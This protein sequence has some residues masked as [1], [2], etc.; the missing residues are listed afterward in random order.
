MPC[1]GR[2][3]R[4]R[5]WIQRR[6]TRSRCQ[7]NTVAGVTIR[8]SRQA[9]DSNPA[10]AANT[11]RSAHDSRG[12]LTWRRSTATHAGGPG[13]PRSSIVCSGPAIRTRP[14]AVGRSDRAV[15]PSRLVIMPDGHWLVMPQVSTV[16]DLFGTHTVRTRS[17]GARPARRSTCCPTAPGYRCRWPYRPP[18]PT[19]PTAS[20]PW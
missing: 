16:D 18:T 19:T 10:S 5:G 6:L 1:N 9:W 13:F 11:A 4:R 2:R 20:S 7:R 3:W 15:V 8:F 12:P 17:T 14:P